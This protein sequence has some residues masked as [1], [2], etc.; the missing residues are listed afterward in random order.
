MTLGADDLSVL[1][2]LKLALDAEALP[3]GA[4]DHATHLIRRLSSPVRIACLGRGQSGKS[5]LINMFV[6]RRVIPTDRKLPTLEV[7]WGAAE[8]LSITAANGAVSDVGLDRL[9]DA[10]LSSAA[11]LRIE[12]PV[13]I[14]KRISFLEVTPDGAPAEQRAAIDWAIRRTDIALWCTQSF[15]NDERELW[16]RV[17]DSLKDHAF[18][19]LSKADKLGAEGTLSDRIAALEEIVSEEFHSLFPVA[20]LHAL[21]AC[22]DDGS[23]DTNMR[24]ASGGGALT[25]EVL[26][27]ADRGRRADMDSAYL[28]LSRYQVRSDPRAMAS[29]AR[30]PSRPSPQAESAPAPKPEAAQSMERTVAQSSLSPEAERVFADGVRFLRRR[31]DGILATAAENGA[32]TPR[33]VIDQCVDTVE[34]LV[35]LFSQGENDD[36]DTDDFIDELSEAAEMM[37]LMQLED[38]DAPAADAATLLLQL[39]RDMET[40]LAA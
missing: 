28:F 38:G 39:R 9:N 19:V 18:L 15:T 35:D 14:L 12:L 32:G 30:V 17:P 16:S 3:S 25:D 8:R 4:R 2:R 29:E 20:T 31:G 37:V 7:V 34:H 24:Q 33:P 36:A 26:R 27:H 10:G 21:A 5:E 23:T 11:F 6:G 22:R 13:E 1:D 40:R